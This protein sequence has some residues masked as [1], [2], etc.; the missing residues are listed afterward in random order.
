VVW[1]ANC[2][3]I[4]GPTRKRRRIA[5]DMENDDNDEGKTGKYNRQ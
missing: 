3:A 2:Y 5:R 4:S 1:I